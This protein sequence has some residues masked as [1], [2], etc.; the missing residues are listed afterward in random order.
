MKRLIVCLF[1][2]Y[3]WLIA[4]CGYAQDTINLMAEAAFDQQ[5]LRECDGY[6]KGAVRYN[7][8]VNAFEIVGG[9]FSSIGLATESGGFGAVGFLLGFG[10][11]EMSKSIPIPLTKARRS[12][13]LLTRPWRDSLGYSRLYK[14][15]TTTETLGYAT[16]VLTFAG[17]ILVIAGGVTDQ[18]EARE[19]L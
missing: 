14:S 10:G 13:D 5:L 1:V 11:M 9:A 3:C 12:L 19:P 6:L 15:V 18:N 2:L 7:S 16:L 17:E 4:A 8:V